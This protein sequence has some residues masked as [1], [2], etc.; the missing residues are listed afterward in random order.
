MLKRFSL[1]SKKH[2]ISLLILIILIASV[3]VAVYLVQQSSFFRLRAAPEVELYF[4]PASAVVPPSTSVNLALDANTNQIGFIA[5]QVQFNHTLV[6]LKSEVQVLNSLTRVI[7]ITPMSEANQTGLIT[8]VLGLEPGSAAPTS[9]FQFAKLEFDTPVTSS[10]T[11]AL[12]YN[13]QNT[14]IVNLQTDELT[15]LASTGEIILNP[16]VNATGELKLVPQSTNIAV[17]SIVPFNISMA[18]GGANI[19]SISMRITTQVTGTNPELSIVDSQGNSISQLQLNNDLLITG[20]WVFPVNSISEQNGN[21][22]IEF[23]AINNSLTGYSNVN[24]VNLG[25]FYLLANQVTESPIEFKFDNTQTL[26]LNKS[27][28][29]QNVLLSPSPVQLSVYLPTAAI[30]SIRFK[31]QGINNQGITKVMNLSFESGQASAQYNTAFL[32]EVAGTFQNQAEL[33]LTNLSVNN[34][35]STYEVFA[36]TPGWLRKRLGSLTIVPGPNAAPP[37]WSDITLTAGDFDNN[38]RLDIQDIGLIL[39]QYTQLSLSV[40][41]SNAIYD[42]DASNTINI[43]DIAIVLSNY[44]AL[45]ISGD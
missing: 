44:T 29:P 25:T 40:T 41:S 22:T 42:L 8:I 31:L 32:S 34:D 43:N 26:M 33:A 2:L 17:G 27:L 28:N 7:D 38:N 39:G 10:G 1:V 16:Q 13:I 5:T 4:E 45:Q 19:S 18:T 21:I 11:S 37:E 30:D 24:F 9:I 20:D 3:P 36:K 6:Q 15:P 12:S 35:G 23:S 14:Q